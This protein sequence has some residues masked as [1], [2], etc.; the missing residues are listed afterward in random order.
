[1]KL[2]TKKQVNWLF[3][4]NIKVGEWYMFPRFGFTI[5]EKPFIKGSYIDT[6]PFTKSLDNQYFVVKEKINGFCR[7]NFQHK[8]APT[9][10]Y[11]EERE[12]SNRNLIEFFFLLIICFIPMILYNIYKKLTKRN[13]EKETK[14]INNLT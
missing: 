8:P 3:S 7:G 11:L 4:K 14:T 5:Y 9:D 6:N 13:Y 1:M 12:L 2:L 10:F